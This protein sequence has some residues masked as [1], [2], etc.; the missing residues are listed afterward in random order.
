MNGSNV[1]IGIFDSG[2]GG[3]S[4][5]AELIRLLPAERFI[6]YADS[7]FAPYG[8]R[9]REEILERCVMIAEDLTRRGVKALVVACNTATSSSVLEMRKRFPISIIGMEPALK[10]A[11]EAGLQGKIVV[12]GTSFTIREKK[13]QE[14]LRRYSE[15][16]EIV[17]LACPGIVELIEQG[18]LESPEM[19]DNLKGLL[20]NLPLV[21]FSAV[22]LGCTHFVFLRNMLRE[23]FDPRVRFF[24][25]NLGTANQ[26]K[27]ILETRNILAD[28]AVSP[29]ENERIS[30]DTSGDPG[31]VLPLCRTLL[32]QLSSIFP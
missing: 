31:H 10:P 15:Q 8:Q 3:I 22:V 23:M 6:Y 25:G 27:R 26:V 7:A 12:L 18:K 4:V 20:Q 5:L 30:L 17:S 2:V 19:R 29:E 32:S 16:K 1:P 14:L 9:S 21:D 24:D 11:V 28:A 13:Y